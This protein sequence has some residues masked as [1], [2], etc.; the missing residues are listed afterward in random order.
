MLVLFA[1]EHCSVIIFHCRVPRPFLLMHGAPALA[2]YREWI[3][4]RNKLN[5]LPKFLVTTAD[6]AFVAV[7]G[8]TIILPP[9]PSSK[10]SLRTVK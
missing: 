3:S 7:S 4:D 6:T 5:D 8:V 9:P 1:Q 2:K 10:H